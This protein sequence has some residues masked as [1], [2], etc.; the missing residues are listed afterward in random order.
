M[1]PDVRKFPIIV[2]QGYIPRILLLLEKV[3]P[4]LAFKGLVVDHFPTIV[5]M[6]THTTY[7]GIALSR[8]LSICS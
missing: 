6:L 3:F 5:K 2:F 8:K 1:A 7:A 4:Q